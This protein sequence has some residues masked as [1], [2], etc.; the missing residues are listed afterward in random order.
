MKVL[1]IGGTGLIGSEAA[2]ELIERGHAVKSLALPPIPQGA[3]LHEKMEVCLCNLMEM[4]DAELTKHMEGYEGF[5]FAAGIDE[6][7]SAPAP[8]YEVFKKYNIDALQRVLKIAKQIGIKHSVVC[9][10]YFTCFDRVRPEEEFTKWHPYIRSRVDQL[11]M[12]LSF[13]DQNFDIAVL[14]QLQRK[15]Y[16]KL[17]SIKDLRFLIF[18]VGTTDFLVRRRG[19]IYYHMPLKWYG[20]VFEHSIKFRGGIGG[21]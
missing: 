9:G 5:V 6:R 1:M 17:L 21:V 11:N 15:L 7:I 20:I 2:R 18:C 16:A 13:A 14:A 12:C 10:S 19:R 8:I 3:C 4:S